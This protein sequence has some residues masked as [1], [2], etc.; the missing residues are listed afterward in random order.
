MSIHIPKFNWYTYKVFIKSFRIGLAKLAT[1]SRRINSRKSVIFGLL[2]GLSAPPLTPS[3]AALWAR[4]EISWFMNSGGMLGARG[5][6]IGGAVGAA[7]GAVVVVLPAGVPVAVV[8]LV[9]EAGVPIGACASKNKYHHD[10]MK[11]FYHYLL[12]EM[13]HCT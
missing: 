12:G 2:C 10:K 5:M 7:P 9:A 3:A 1:S 11:Y 4:R 8:L 6:P 13:S